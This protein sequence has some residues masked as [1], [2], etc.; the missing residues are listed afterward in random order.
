MVFFGPRPRGRSWALFQTA[1]VV[2]LFI[3]LQKL[4]SIFAWADHTYGNVRWYYDVGLLMHERG[5]FN[6]WTSYP[7][8]FPALLYALSAFQRE[9]V[10]F[11]NFWKI[12]NVLLVAGIAYVIFKIL[13]EKGRQRALLA[14]F[15]FVLINATYNSRLTIGL[16]MDQFDY[17]P[18]FLMLVSLY[19]LIKRRDALSAV[20]SG[21][22]TMTKVFPG[23]ILLIALFTLDKRQK[24]V[25]LAVFAVTC[26]VILLPYFIGGMEPLISLYNYSASRD[27]WETVWHYPQIKFPP[28][29][30]TE[31]L[32]SPFRSDAR[33]Y[34]WL[35]WLGAASMLACMI[36]QRKGRAGASLPQQA[37]CLLILFL[38][39]SKGVSSYFVFWIFPLF[40][41]CYRPPVAFVLCAVFLLV[42]NIEFFVDTYWLSI[43]TRHIL[44]IALLL[45]Q[46]IAQGGIRGYSDRRSTHGEA[47][48]SVYP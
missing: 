30:E 15:G 9:L 22:G 18:T 46:I 1:I 11:I 31:P 43:W 6:I 12:L 48:Q 8:V 41:L 13:E 25:Y 35:G 33:P 16:Y 29:T 21:I 44:F 27:A 28:P 5:F 2:I 7:P 36:W 10:G 47:K 4:L 3:F 23:V 17:L 37:L 20:F 39:F 19:L 26:L 34:A 40:F 14:T 24:I 32:L 38:I 42:G 45:Q